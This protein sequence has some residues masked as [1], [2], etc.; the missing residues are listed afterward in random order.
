MSTCGQ[1]TKARKQHFPSLA[2]LFTNPSG[3]PIPVALPPASQ[4]QTPGHWEQ[5]HQPTQQQGVKAGS[6]FGLTLPLHLC[7]PAPG[8]PLGSG[9]NQRQQGLKVSQSHR[10]EAVSGR[11]ALL[12]VGSGR[13]NKAMGTQSKPGSHLPGT[14]EAEAGG[15]Q[16]LDYRVSP[17]GHRGQQSKIL[18]QS[19][20]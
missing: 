6:D 16:I 2:L 18:S 12:R 13:S 1:S 9:I 15:L 5:P 10:P 14:W 8:S 19:E 7:I 3:G 17:Q 4:G 11:T 20:Q